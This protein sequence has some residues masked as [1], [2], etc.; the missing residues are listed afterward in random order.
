MPPSTT[1]S[2]VQLA[3]AAT[4]AAAALA[5]AAL[6]SALA[7]ATLATAALAT[8][9]LASLAPAFTACL[10]AF[11]AGFGCAFRVILEIPAASRSAFTCNFTDFVF[12]HRREAALGRPAALITTIVLSHFLTPR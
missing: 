2:R 7:T 8:A 6:A 5:A 11:T 3:V 1:D 12:V 4:L 9:A 10:A